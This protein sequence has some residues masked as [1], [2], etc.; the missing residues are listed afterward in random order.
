MTKSTDSEKYVVVYK[1]RPG[2][3]REYLNACKTHSEICG[4]STSLSRTRPRKNRNVVHVPEPMR[5]RNGVESICVARNGVLS[6]EDA[7]SEVE[8]ETFQPVREIG[9]TSRDRRLKVSTKVNKFKPAFSNSKKF[10]SKLKDLLASAV[11][12]GLKFCSFAIWDS[13]GIAMGWIP[14]PLKKY[15]SVFNGIG[16]CV[17]IPHGSR[18]FVGIGNCVFIPHGRIGFIR[19]DL[20]LH[21]E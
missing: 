9:E 1:V 15:T 18:F 8:D 10:P 12:D 16:I 2:F 7:R 21:Q 6:E 3:R 4:G 19:M 20:V 13:H 11:L 17:L 5:T 14:P